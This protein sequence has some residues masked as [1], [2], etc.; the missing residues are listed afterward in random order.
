MKRRKSPLFGLILVSYTILLAYWMFFGFS[1]T[2]GDLFM[3][4]LT[5]FSTIKKYFIYFDHFNLL[6]WLI[7]IVGNIAVFVPFGILFPLYSTQYHSFFKFLFTFLIGITSLETLQLIF[8]VGSFD[9]D[10]II[11]NTSG[12][13]IGFIFYS[14]FKKSSKKGT[15]PKGA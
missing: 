10:D 9:V 12:A 6:T 13:I 1:R 4:N 2:P 15:S 3:Y 8:R 5:P 14:M 7:N 11:L